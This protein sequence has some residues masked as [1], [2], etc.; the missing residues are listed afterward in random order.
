M[1]AILYTLNEMANDQSLQERIVK[2]SFITLSLTLL[3]SIFA[4][5]IRILYSHTLTI[6]NYGLFY[7]VFASFNILVGYGDLG[8]GY[9]IVYLL[10]KYLKIKNYSKAWNIF[11]YGQT[12][13]L[14]MAI[15]LAIVLAIFAPFLAKNYFKIAGSENLVYIFCIYLIVFTVLNGLIQIFIGMQKVKYYSSITVSRWFLTFIFSALFF[16]FDFPNIV[17]YALSWALGHVLTAAFFLFL[18]LRKHPYLIRNKIIWESVIL[19]QMFSLAYPVVLENFVATS[20]IFTETFLLTLIKG[21]RDVGIYNIIYP[22]TSVSIILLAPINSLI[23]P[24]VSHLMEG[25]KERIKYLINRILEITPFIGVYFS[26]FLISFPSNIVG[27]IFGQKWVGLVETPLVILSIGS[28]GFLMSEILGTVAIGTGKIKARLKANAILGIFSVGLDIFLIWKYG[29]LGVVITNSLIR[30]AL[31]IWC[32]KIIKT[33]VS[34]QMPLRFY[35][36]ILIFS[37]TMFLTVKFIGISPKNW[38]ELII[39][40][41]LYTIFFIFL[42]L[43]LK[44]YD[45]KLIL[46]I[47]PKKKMDT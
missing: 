39:I 47:M 35:L 45:K 1:L 18:F 34:F 37:I 9:A 14:T 22:L 12:I 30:L 24:L 42:G 41:I 7:A 23:L 36:K 13:S 21:V 2:G 16:L 8:F 27:L 26:L 11:V 25:E 19:K 20:M 17:F 43:I 28:I 32:L 4:Y 44:I 10:P 15:L 46:M 33:S 5:L 31:S 29:V 6:E 3:G 38:F 40:G